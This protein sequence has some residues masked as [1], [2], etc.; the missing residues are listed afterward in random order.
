MNEAIIEAIGI[1]SGGE[2]DG[3]RADEGIPVN[4]ASSPDNTILGRRTT[5]GS[6]IHTKE[7]I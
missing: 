3:E 7:L 6:S 4:R 5:L 1:L 2:P